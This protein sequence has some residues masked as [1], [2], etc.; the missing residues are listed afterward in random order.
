MQRN[1][2][3]RTRKIDI[4]I[5]TYQSIIVHD[6]FFIYWIVLATCEWDVLVVRLRLVKRG[7]CDLCLPRGLMRD[8]ET[9]NR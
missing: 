3:E 5:D 6:T 9:E 7:T 8:H 1:T 2:R 4:A